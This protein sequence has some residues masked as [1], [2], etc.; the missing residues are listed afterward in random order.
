ELDLCT[1]NGAMIA[2]AAGMRL[3]AGQGQLQPGYIFDVKPRWPLGEL[4]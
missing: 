2:L 1:D 3:Q 4:V